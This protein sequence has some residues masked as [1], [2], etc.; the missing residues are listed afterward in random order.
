MADAFGARRCK[1]IL[2]VKPGIKVSIGLKNLTKPQHH[3]FLIYKKRMQCSLWNIKSVNETLTGNEWY[4]VCD[5]AMGTEEQRHRKPGS[6]EPTIHRWPPLGYMSFLNAPTVSHP[7]GKHTATLESDRRA[8]SLPHPK[9]TKIPVLQEC[10][11]TS[12]RAVAHGAAHA[13]VLR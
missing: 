1:S 13:G 4:G 6:P 2:R 11:S 5:A 3:Y 10:L 12:G 9:P 7:P 8:P